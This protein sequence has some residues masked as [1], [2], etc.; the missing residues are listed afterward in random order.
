MKAVGKISLGILG[1]GTV[2]SALVDLI[3]AE[4]SNIYADTG[5]QLE[6]VK[7]GVK[8]LNRQRPSS[9]DRSLLT[10]D[11]QAIVND[12]DIDII[13]ELMGGVDP[14]RELLKAALKNSTPVVSANKEVLAKYSGDLFKSAQKGGVRL[15]FEASVA[16]AIPVIRTLQ[17]SLLGESVSRI[18]GILNGTTNYILSSITEDSVGYKAAL[19]KA[20]ELGYAERDPSDDV[21]GKDSAY[22][23]AILA[24]L[25]FGGTVDINHIYCEGIQAVDMEDIVYA[26]QM[27]Y[28]LKLLATAEKTTVQKRSNQ[29]RSKTSGNVLAIRVHPAMVPSQHPLAKV[30][31]SYNAV[32]IEG[33]A[34]GQLMLSGH[35]A[36]GEPTAAAVLGDILD[37]AQRPMS[38]SGHSGN[39]ISTPAEVLSIDELSV[40]YYLRLEVQDSPGVLAEVAKAFG[41]NN[42]SIRSMEQ[43]P[44]N[45]GS[46]DLPNQS[47]KGKKQSKKQGKKGLASLIFITHIAEE[48]NFQATLKALRSIKSVKN[49]LTSL[50][51]MDFENY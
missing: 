22:K 26:Q 18:T 19:T 42:V 20:Q 44:K 12:P 29:K 35:G 45:S 31:G 1:C 47:A 50:R 39:E 16:G 8:S 34:I 36:G 32:Y 30:S 21:S 41:E 51:V 9:I 17:H 6:V 14:A 46:L 4:R 10:Q 27:G 28:T 15:A 40:A 2:G 38:P 11:L 33:S 13:V 3:S 49:I 48:K 5:I 25:A 24:S 43:L 7:I 37:L 23:I